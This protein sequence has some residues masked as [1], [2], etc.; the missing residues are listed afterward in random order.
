M[1]NLRE[2]QGVCEEPVAW[3]PNDERNET[4]AGEKVAN[5]S[6]GQNTEE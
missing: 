1:E 2:K 6:R 3:N 5:I 4:G